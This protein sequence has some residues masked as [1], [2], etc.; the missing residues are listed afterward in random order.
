MDKEKI[1]TTLASVR[2]STGTMLL[3]LVGILGFIIAA[4]GAGNL[5][6]VQMTFPAV[7]PHLVTIG[8]LAAAGD[9][10]LR[11]LGDLLDNGKIDGSFPTGLGL[12]LLPFLG[13]F[14]LLSVSCAN[15]GLGVS[16]PDAE[17]CYGLTSTVSGRTYTLGPCSNE[18]GAIFQWRAVWTNKDGVTIR[19]TK[20][21]PSLTA[22]GPWKLA[23]MPKGGVIWIVYDSKAGISLDGLPP[24]VDISAT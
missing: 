17:G 9:K 1:E 22:K 6:W 2:M 18:T 4:L 13:L 8:L 19:A 20:K 3:R 12:F 16:L 10:G 7:A 24:Q 14:C 11:W 21:G 15:M 5:E 23:Y